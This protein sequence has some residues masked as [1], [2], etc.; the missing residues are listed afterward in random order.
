MARS[1]SMLC[2]S[3]LSLALG[4][5]ADPDEGSGF[6]TQPASDAG[7]SAEGESGGGSTGGPGG[8]TGGA[9]ETG[10]VDSGGDASSGGAMFVERPDGGGSNECDVWAQDCPPG[11][12][13]MPWANDGGS[14]WNSLRC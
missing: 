5:A 2:S 1:R 7:S 6:A 4:C 8:E 3:A 12:K 13:C 9:T 10:V 14:S 11:E